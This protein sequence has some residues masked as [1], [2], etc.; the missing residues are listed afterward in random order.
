LFANI[1]STSSEPF[2]K[3]GWLVL[4]MSEGKQ[5]SEPMRHPDINVLNTSCGDGADSKQEHAGRNSYSSQT[6]NRYHISEHRN[7]SS[8]RTDQ[9]S[10]G[11]KRARE[12]S[13]NSVARSLGTEHGSPPTKNA[14][15]KVAA[16]E[17]FFNMVFE[18]H[19]SPKPSLSK[20]KHIVSGRASDQGFV[21]LISRDASDSIKQSAPKK[22]GADLLV[23]RPPVLGEREAKK[24]RK[25]KGLMI[26]DSDSS[27][28]EMDKKKTATKLSKSLSSSVGDSASLE[29][30]DNNIKGCPSSDCSRN[31]STP[32]IC[33]EV[34]GKGNSKKETPKV[35]ASV[36]ALL[37]SITARKKTSMGLSE[38]KR[39]DCEQ[40][41]KPEASEGNDV[42]CLVDSSDED[43]STIDAK[44][45]MQ[46]VKSPQPLEIKQCKQ[47]S[48]SDTSKSAV[49]N[50][51]NSSIIQCKQSSATSKG[52]SPKTSSIQRAQLND[53]S[54]PSVQSLGT[55]S[56]QASR[57]LESIPN[58]DNQ[59]SVDISWHY[60]QPGPDDPS[61]MTRNGI[62]WHWCK[63]CNND[64]GRWSTHST[65]NHKLGKFSFVSQHTSSS[66]DTTK[67]A[68][69]EQKPFSSNFGN[70][71]NDPIFI[72]SSDDE[73]PIDRRH[74]PSA[75]RR[76]AKKSP[77]K[78]P[79]ELPTKNSSTNNTKT[80]LESKSTG[81]MSDM[82]GAHRPIF[83]DLLDSDDESMGH[84]SIVQKQ[85]LGENNKSS[86]DENESSPALPDLN[87]GD[88]GDGKGDTFSAPGSPDSPSHSDSKK[89]HAGAMQVL[90][91][92]EKELQ[93]ECQV[94][95]KFAVVEEDKHYAT[96]FAYCMMRQYICD[97][98]NDEDGKQK[99]G[100][101]CLKCVHC[102]KTSSAKSVSSMWN[103]LSLF[104][105][106]LNVEC[107]KVP[108]DIKNALNC[109][110][111]NDAEQRRAD[112]NIAIQKF[113]GAVFG[114]M[115]SAGI[116]RP[117]ER[118]SQDE[119]DHVSPGCEDPCEGEVHS[120]CSLKNDES[121]PGYEL[122]EMRVIDW[123]KAL[124]KNHYPTVLFTAWNEKK[125]KTFHWFVMS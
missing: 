18:S 32:P 115:V 95:I 17:D 75:V 63:L 98:F 125:G 58:T 121:M 107:E 8:I 52:Q 83:I 97:M 89:A 64:K 120:S 78:P 3:L 60:I 117:G 116:V 65:E 21:S 36:T 30:K 5:T 47:S 54:K 1:H 123:H 27:D 13:S 93:R 92:A 112:S 119:N 80:E 12:V 26:D 2:D 4:F 50:P 66:F 15:E 41:E 42:I 45:Q 118:D 22:C 71:C 86:T 31:G 111:Q 44:S 96:D 53:T 73:A 9:S 29:T 46:T 55:S 103:R 28:D 61:S 67:T 85:N 19:M 110:K 113:M 74:F 56:I 106:H 20:S 94:P 77:K 108:K 70:S 57:A 10:R 102:G 90:V 76:V 48:S 105:K 16:E 114:N 91:S 72:L 109:L 124:D 25:I 49:Q 35:P 68:S 7:N 122:P 87:M 37:A 88:N 6:S 24:V 14:R 99:S 51:K 69:S 39:N 43:T 62:Q 59:P 23:Q 81:K 104:W 33:L 40:R 38:A 82:K 34:D 84:E 100:Y 11:I 101:G 79:I